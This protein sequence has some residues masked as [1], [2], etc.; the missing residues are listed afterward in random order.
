M[1][2]KI[3]RRK[4]VQG[5]AATAAGGAAVWAAETQFPMDQ[6]AVLEALAATVLPSKEIRPKTAAER[7]TKWVRGYAPNA[8]ME[9][10]YGITKLES[11]PG[12][13]ALAYLEQLRALGK[14]GFVAMGA[15]E[16]KAAVEEILAGLQLKSLPRVPACQ[17]VVVDLM[18]FYFFS[19][20]ATDQCYGVAIRSGACRGFK[21]VGNVPEKLS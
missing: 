2:K 4:V 12:S 11:R 21:N 1:S 13:P 18:S 8:E 9:H 17:N 19:P 5:I 10:G 16:R 3:G 20:D 6:G 7:F 14:K 15:G